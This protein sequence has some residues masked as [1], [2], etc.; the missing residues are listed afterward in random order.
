M[1]RKKQTEKVQIEIWCYNILHE[2]EGLYIYIFKADYIYSKQIPYKD[3][4]AQSD[5]IFEN[6]FDRTN[7]I[8]KIVTGRTF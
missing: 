4:K 1:G 3:M 6:I 8:I 2:K 7:N 5:I